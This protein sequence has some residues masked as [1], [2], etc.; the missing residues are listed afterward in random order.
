MVVILMFWRQDDVHR[1]RG[2][3]F[4]LD[5]SPLSMKTSYNMV[6][7]HGPTGDAGQCGSRRRAASVQFFAK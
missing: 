7:G 4:V 6:I 1:P 2:E 3:F 5:M